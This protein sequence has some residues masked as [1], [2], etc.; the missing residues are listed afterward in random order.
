M[1]PALWIPWSFVGGFVLLVAAQAA[2]VTI[3]IRSDTGLVTDTPY[4]E[5][6]HYNATLDRLAEDRRR[7]WQLAVAFTSEGGGVIHAGLSDR[8]GQ[9][10]TAEYQGI[11]ERRTGTHETIPLA[12]S[13]NEARFAPKQAGRWFIHVVARHGTQTEMKLSEIFVAP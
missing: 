13:G 2:F 12:F 11:A 9:A 4:V 3:A 8:V 1:K 7:G 10:L 6:L 5:G